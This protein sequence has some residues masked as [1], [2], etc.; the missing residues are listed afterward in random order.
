MNHQP[1]PIPPAPSRSKGEQHVPWDRRS[2]LAEAQPQ[3]VEFL[4]CMI[5]DPDRAKAVADEAIAA[6]SLDTEVGHANKF[7]ESL[8]TTARSFAVDAWNATLAEARGKAESS[9]ITERLRALMGPEREVILLSLRLGFDDGAIHRITDFTEK[10][11]GDLR[12]GAIGAL[13]EVGVT[14]EALR[15]CLTS[16]ESLTPLE[17]EAP[18]T[19][20]LSQVIRRVRGSRYPKHAG[21]LIMLLGLAGL[22]LGW[23]LVNRFPELIEALRGLLGQ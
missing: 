16:R 3:L 1:P 11:V 8:Y 20:A 2:F 19:L 6:M 17:S 4:A 15:S 9:T 18:E 5:G 21:P 12:L 7:K 14:L 22:A 23:W 10:R 13:A